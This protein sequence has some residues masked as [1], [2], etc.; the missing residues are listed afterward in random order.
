MDAMM[1]VESCEKDVELEFDDL[2]HKYISG[3]CSDRDEDFFKKTKEL[4][5]TDD[6]KLS[7]NKIEEL[8]KKLK[9]MVGF[10]TSSIT[11]LM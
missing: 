9:K 6:L 7:I 1:V 4:Y 10:N 8:Q 3:K 11:L 5:K 2:F